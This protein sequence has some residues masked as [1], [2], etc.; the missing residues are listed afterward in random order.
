MRHHSHQPT[1]DWLVNTAKSNPEGLLLLAAGCALLLRSGGSSDRSERPAG[2]RQSAQPGGTRQRTRANESSEH[3]ETGYGIAEAV[4]QTADSAR[5]YASD[6]GKKVSETAGGYASTVSDYADTARRSVA[7]QS[8]HMIE[9]AQD[10]FRRV[11]QEQP[12]AIA[13]LGLAA[14]AAVALALPMTAVEREQLGPARGR[15]S[16]VAS[17]YGV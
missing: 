8:E 10:T 4:S 6:L 7:D 9:H 1:S 14:G 2:R 5:E 3:D 12:L 11:L 16:E 17:C 15:I 13:A